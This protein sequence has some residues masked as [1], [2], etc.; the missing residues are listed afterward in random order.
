MA[1]EIYSASDIEGNLIVAENNLEL[2][3]TKIKKNGKKY[4]YSDEMIS[5]YKSFARSI[6][7]KAKLLK[8]LTNQ[9]KVF[10]VKAF[11]ERANRLARR[12]DI[13]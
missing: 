3:I 7:R 13:I 9:M 11:T 4:E 10:D 1:D 8:K 2:A 12:V 5:N 6:E